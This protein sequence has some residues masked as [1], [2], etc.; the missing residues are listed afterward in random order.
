VSLH[1]PRAAHAVGIG[2]ATITRQPVAVAVLELICGGITLIVQAIGTAG[3]GSTTLTG[4]ADAMVGACI[5][6]V[7]GEAIRV[8]DAWFVGARTAH[9]IRRVAAVRAALLVFGAGDGVTVSRIAVGILSGGRGLRH[10]NIGWTQFAAR[11]AAGACYAV[12]VV[13]DNVARRALVDTGAVLHEGLSRWAGT[14]RRANATRIRS[15]LVWRAHGHTLAVDPIR[16]ILKWANAAAL[17]LVV[18]GPNE[19]PCSV[20]PVPRKAVGARTRGISSDRNKRRGLRQ[21]AERGACRSLHQ[22]LHVR[23]FR[24][25]HGMNLTVRNEGLDGNGWNECVAD[26]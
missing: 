11:R 18:G 10:A 2:V 5:F 19:R 9:A 16:E 15:R 24:V 12:P 22:I 13:D 1:A 8:T 14:C 7:V 25:V 26:T 6:A 21:K 20:L 23:R 17:A 3:T 4:L